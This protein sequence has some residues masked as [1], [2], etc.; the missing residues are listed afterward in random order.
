MRARF[1]ASHSAAIAALTLYVSG[2]GGAPPPDPKPAPPPEN[3]VIATGNGDLVSATLGPRGGRLNL[4]NDGPSI[5]IPVDAARQD[6]LSISMRKEEPFTPPSGSRLGES[7]RVTLALDPPSGG[8]FAV[9]S[10]AMA[11]LPPG[12]TESNIELGVE[13]PGTV[14]PA[15]GESSPALEWEYVP[16]KFVSAHATS[17]VPRFWPHRLQF[18]CGRAP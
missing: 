13:R 15:D 8:S 10:A 3:P 2:C 7:F 18:L 5:E 14:G 6:G 1:S 16:A 4:A 12:C 11:A 17:S 9:F